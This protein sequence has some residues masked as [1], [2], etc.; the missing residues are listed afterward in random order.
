V[1]WCHPGTTNVLAAPENTP[2]LRAHQHQFD[3][4]PSVC[5]GTVTR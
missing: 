3:L 2:S 4:D 5:P 1:T